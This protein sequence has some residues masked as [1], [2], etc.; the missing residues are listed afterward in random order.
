MLRHERGPAP[1]DRPVR[2]AG[3][4]LWLLALSRLV[5]RRRWVRCCGDP[6]DAA[7]LAP[8][9]VSPSG[10]TGRRRP[11]GRLRQ[12]RSELVIH[13]A[14]D[15]RAWGHPRCKANSSGSAIR[16]RP[17]RCGRS[18]IMPVSAPRPPHGPD[19]EQFLPRRPRRPRGQLVHVNTVLLRRIYALIVIEHGTRR[20]PGWHDR[21]P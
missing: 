8:R 1:S 2:Y 5:P 14:T 11:D 12:P 19:L 7:R 3:D 16:S 17:L 4:R 13:M 15:N 18:C 9:S 10:T 21:Q 20:S 6:S